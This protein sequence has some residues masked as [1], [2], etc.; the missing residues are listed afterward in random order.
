MDFAMFI[1]SSLE[2]PGQ[3]GVFFVPKNRTMHK[4]MIPCQ[5]KL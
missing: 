3:E 4:E 1:I 2:R 5:E